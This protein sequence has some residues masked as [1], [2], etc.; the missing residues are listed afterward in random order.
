MARLD[1][2]DAADPHPNRARARADRLTTARQRHS[3]RGARARRRQNRRFCAAWLAR[4]PRRWS[5]SALSRV[6]DLAQHRDVEAFRT[7]AAVGI[8]PRV[9][10]GIAVL[11]RWQVAVEEVVAWTAVDQVAVLAA[12]KGV[13]SWATDHR[14]GPEA[15]NDGVVALTTLAR[16]VADRERQEVVAVTAVDGVVTGTWKHLVIAGA[17]VDHVCA[18]WRVGVAEERGSVAEDDIVTAEPIDG[19]V[20]ESATDEIRPV[21]ARQRL[22]GIGADDDVELAQ[23]DAGVR[24]WIAVRGHRDCLR[25]QCTRQHD[26]R[27]YRERDH[28]Q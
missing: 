23:I 15:A 6:G 9:G 16:V 25:R 21:S 18:A 2:A 10:R 5:R 19:V 1:P 17:G 3:S 26:R 27:G 8:R 12:C 20:T 7:D 28:R 4:A 22:G 11:V 24:A 13:V 14:V